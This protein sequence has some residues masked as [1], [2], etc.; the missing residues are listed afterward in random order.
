MDH[1]GMC[2]IVYPFAPRSSKIPVSV[3]S[4]SS[5]RRVRMSCGAHWCSRDSSQRSVDPTRRKTRHW[6]A[7]KHGFWGDRW[8]HFNDF[9]LE[10]PLGRGMI[11]KFGLNSRSWKMNIYPDR[12]V[13]WCFLEQVTDWSEWSNL[14]LDMLTV[15]YF[16]VF[17]Y[18]LAL[19]P[20][21]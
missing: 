12:L 9:K 11:V 5:W 20:S 13:F 21:I 2:I 15:S 7:A 8:V 3:V 16:S 4:G 6:L 17:Y 1:L 14:F 10:P 19:S 18:S